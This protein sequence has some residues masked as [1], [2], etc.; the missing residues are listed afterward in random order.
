MANEMANETARTTLILSM[1]WQLLM[2]IS[3]LCFRT[4]VGLI[5]FFVYSEYT[6]SFMRLNNTVNL[7]GGLSSR[8]DKVSNPSQ[9]GQ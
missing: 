2:R 9:V 3:K 1:W 8:E 6:L 5:H 4:D 7:F